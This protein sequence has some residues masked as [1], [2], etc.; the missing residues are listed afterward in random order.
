MASVNQN[1]VLAPANNACK[2]N[3]SVKYT[4]CDGVVTVL[5]LVLYVADIVTGRNI[6]LWLL[7]VTHRIYLIQVF[8][9]ILFWVLNI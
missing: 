6:W 3:P 9:Q 8:F 4:L 7:S 2:P 1:P 5:S